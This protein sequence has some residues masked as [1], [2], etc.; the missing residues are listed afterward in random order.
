MNAA[1]NIADA[2][3]LEVA[4]QAWRADA[5]VVAKSG[6]RVNFSNVDSI[7]LRHVYRREFLPVMVGVSLVAS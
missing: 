3:Q 6:E 4:Y 2:I 5:H 7:T 1:A